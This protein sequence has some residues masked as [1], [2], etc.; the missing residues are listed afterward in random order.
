MISLRILDEN[1]E[2]IGEMNLEQ[3][4]MLENKTPNEFILVTKPVAI[5]Q[6]IPIKIG[7]QIRIRCDYA[8]TCSRDFWYTKIGSVTFRKNAD[9][10]AAEIKKKVIPK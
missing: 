7:S 8:D 9:P 4:F 10:G 2:F 6:L 5:V 3:V 1:L